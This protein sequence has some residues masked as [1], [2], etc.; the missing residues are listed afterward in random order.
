MMK[1]FIALICLIGIILTAVAC[2]NGQDVQTSAADTTTLLDDT[3]VLDT[4]DGTETERLDT[5]ETSV[6]TTEEIKPGT[7][8]ASAKETSSETTKKDSDTTTIETDKIEISDEDRLLYEPKSI[9]V[10]MYETNNKLSYGFTW[11][12]YLEP[13]S[14]SFQYKR[15]GDKEYKSISP[16]V[17]KYGTVDINTGK[18][19]PLYVCKTEVEL[20]PNKDY[21]YRIVDITAEVSSAEIELTTV[22]PN[23]KSFK[24]ASISD[25]QSYESGEFLQNA[26]KGIGNVDFYLHTGD[27]CEDTKHEQNWT[28]MLHFNSEYLTKT[29]MMVTAGNHDTTH[30]SGS[31]EVYKHFNNKIPLQG[32]TVSGYFYSFDYGDVKFIVLNTNRLNSQSKLPDLQYN[33]LIDTLENNTKKWT[34]VSMHNPLYSVGKWGSRPDL[35]GVSLALQEQLTGVFA[36]YGVD[37][38][39]QGHDHEI[40]K[41]YPIDEEGNPLT[42][43]KSTINGVEYIVSPD[44]P[45]Y[46]MNGT[47]GNQTRGPESSYRKELYDYAEASYVSGWAEYEVTENTITV[48]VKYYNTNT[49]TP[50]VVHTWGIKK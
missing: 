25:S 24:F 27:I 12:T 8:T 48:S 23:K 50:V 31:N 26:L 9:T 44:A 10:T 13:L 37:L 49:N 20:E 5:T 21:I 43:V 47:S 18:S 2:G 39:I 22:D 45:I 38:V 16:D 34:I 29:P 4:I 6:D 36:K 32:T 17:Y 11:N 30:K 35:N 46:I 15:Q 19:I 28:D 41:T 14:P 3:T 33:W 42:E 7:T 40:S 1:K